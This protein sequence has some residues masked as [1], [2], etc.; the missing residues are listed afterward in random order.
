MI[1]SVEMRQKLTLPLVLGLCEGI[2]TVLTLAT[3][4]LVKSGAL[5]TLGFAVRVSLVSLITGLFVYF[6]SQYSEL[7]R[8]LLHLELEINLTDRGHLATTQL[9]KKII[10]EAIIMTLVGSVFAFLGSFIPLLI[11]ILVQSHKWASLVS[12][13]VLLGILGIF[14]ANLVHGSKVRWILS[15]IISGLLVAYIGLQLDIVS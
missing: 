14:L 7:R 8:E 13:V 3:K 10:N 15:L 6:I 1:L 4:L 12:A 11:A 2:I 5:V 9:G